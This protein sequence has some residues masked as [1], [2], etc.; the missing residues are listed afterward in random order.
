MLKV[1][2]I[3]SAPLEEATLKLMAQFLSCINTCTNGS[4][5][6]MIPRLCSVVRGTSVI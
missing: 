3:N 1:C 2:T 4:T 5:I 6:L